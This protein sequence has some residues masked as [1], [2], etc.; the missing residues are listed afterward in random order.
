[1][2]EYTNPLFRRVYGKAYLDLV[3]R[4]PHLVGFIYDQMD[5]HH[6]AGHRMTDRLLRSVDKLNLQTF[7]E[8][9]LGQPWDLIINTHFLP[10]ERI[11]GCG[12]KGG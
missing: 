2:L 8:W 5:K 1:M 10:A 7:E 11:R 12:S 4:A 3:N 9:L 6:S